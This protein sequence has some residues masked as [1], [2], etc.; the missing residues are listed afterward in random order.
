METIIR[1]ND[2][3]NINGGSIIPYLVQSGDT[4]GALA[5]K[6][7]CT[8][9]DICKWNNITDPNVLSVNQKLIFKF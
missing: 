4:L 5:K 1:D 9:E 3:E 7:N 6:F 2:L 8:I